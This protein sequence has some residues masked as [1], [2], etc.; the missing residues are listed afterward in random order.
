M[1]LSMTEFWRKWH[2]TLGNWFRDYLY[3]PLGG[4]RK[5]PARTFF[6]LFSVWLLTGFWHGASWNFLLWG[7]L[8]FVLISVEKLAL[9]FPAPF[10]V[11][12]TCLHG[13]GNS[14]DLDGI[15][16]TGTV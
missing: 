8:L 4:N 16:I 13:F 11:C 6:N 14:I 1:A 10:S 2:I 5:K 9:A 7:L 12:R 3:I 15:C